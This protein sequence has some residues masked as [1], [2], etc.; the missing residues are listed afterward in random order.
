MNYVKYLPLIFILSIPQLLAAEPQKPH[1]YTPKDQIVFTTATEAAFDRSGKMLTTRVEVDG[2]KTVENNGSFG[3]VTVARL[4]ADGK[5]ETFC[6]T[7]AGAASSW[8]AGESGTLT[9]ASIKPTVI[10]KQ[11]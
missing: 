3:N 1:R 8:M 5:V 10:E 4:N 7:D 6:T 9:T 11:P 2:T